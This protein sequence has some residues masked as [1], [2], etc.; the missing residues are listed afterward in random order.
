MY[1]DAEL[2]QCLRNCVQARPSAG[3]SGCLAF[4]LEEFLC[5]VLEAR[6][7]LR[8]P[9]ASLARLP[10]LL[11]QYRSQAPDCRLT[12][13]DLLLEGWLSPFLD[14]WDFS[15]WP[16]AEDLEGR[17]QPPAWRERV[18]FLRWL[19]ERVGEDRDI[20]VP[21][22]DR[23]LRDFQAIFPQMPCR[24]WFIQEGY[25]SPDGQCLARGRRGDRRAEAGALARLWTRWPAAQG[26]TEERADRWL[27]LAMALGGMWG[28]FEQLPVE[29]R[30]VLLERIIIRLERGRYPDLLAEN[31][32]IVLAETWRRSPE[33][34]DVQW[35]PLSGDIISDLYRFEHW[36]WDWNITLYRRKR[37]IH[38]YLRVLCD[39]LMLLE[40]E[41]LNRA[42]EVIALLAPIGC[43]HELSLPPES[44][45]CLW[46]N[47]KTSLLAC[48]RMFS[49]GLLQPKA[50]D[51]LLEQ[52]FRR[53]VE[54]L[55]LAPSRPA[56]GVELSRLLLFFARQPRGGRPDELGN[57]LLGQLLT[58][59]KRNRRVMEPQLETIACELGRRMEQEEDRLEWCCEFRLVC[60]LTR[61]LYYYRGGPP[62]ARD[63][64]SCRRLRAVLFNQYVR[65]FCTDVRFLKG[66][67]GLLDMDCFSGEV[68]GDIY[69]ER[70]DNLG[71]M[72]RFLQP[73][74]RSDSS[75][76]GR[77]Y[78]YGRCEIHLAML[79]ALMK[80]RKK[81]DP[82]LEPVFARFLTRVLLPE[83]NLL[84]FD[85]IVTTNGLPLVKEA[86]S[87][88]CAG[89]KNDEAFFQAL[90]RFDLPELVL[91]YCG[92]RDDALKQ[93]CLQLIQGQGEVPA[94]PIIHEEAL[95]QLILDGEIQC[96]YSMAERMLARQMDRW[97]ARPG[98]ALRQTEGRAADQLNRVWLLK[99]DYA[100]ILD[101]GTPFF[102]AVV[103]MESQEHR[104]LPRA[105]RIWQELLNERF[106][107]AYAINLI[108][109]YGLLYQEER[110][111]VLDRV[112]E[113]RERVEHGPYAS[114]GRQEK[115]HYAVNLFFLYRQGTTDQRKLIDSLCE[116]LGV[117]RDLF[118]KLPDRLEA[119]APQLEPVELSAENPVPALRTYCTAPLRQKAEWFFQMRS[120]DLEG[121]PRNALLTWCVMN[122]CAHLA[123][124]APQ[125]LVWDRLY[126]DRCTQLFRELFN[127]AYPQ[128]FSLAV[129]DQ[130]QTGRTASL[131]RQGQ[132]G[133]AEVDITFKE[134]GRVVAIGEALRLCSLEKRQ[135]CQHIHKL[136]GNN[137]LEVPM[138]LLV[139]VKHDQPDS[140]WQ[141][142]ESYV[143]EVF[144]RQ[145]GGTHWGPALV[146]E[147][148][149]CEDYIPGIHDSFRFHRHMLCVT[150][151]NLERRLPPMY[152]LFLSVGGQ[153][154]LSAAAAAR[155]KDGAR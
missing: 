123:A 132:A 120:C 90:E 53:I 13:E 18:A 78:A 37:V 137:L 133:I 106:Q 34:R 147:F 129:N 77:I 65:L 140:L 79:T 75:S 57:R 76:D 71:E 6:A 99:K 19:I 128:I 105:E 23:V 44:M 118:E 58:V 111:A 144:S 98:P 125:L 102:Q 50:W 54:K 31:R 3:G 46:N 61:E 127:Q 35:Q 30:R 12:A 40:D 130:E 27:D 8:A 94:H 63:V 114:W 80:C 11:E 113:L 20:F 51:H 108:Y 49:Q 59:L 122:T 154:T 92:A 85:S 153:E 82:V 55:L 109:T 56:D 110:N 121:D 142:Y 97:R 87:L 112:E 66:A 116:E 146:K 14:W 74:I 26:D 95:I 107:P 150:F 145:P 70:R 124:F 93:R 33:E 45:L 39:N 41:L 24:D 126:E 149:Q 52:A 148:A 100:R 134:Q 60:L 36:G 25:L 64:P 4:P 81:A 21:Q 143:R 103:Y 151:G 67:P 68:W 155:G 138:F 104:D 115:E 29:Q 89:R 16:G 48:E 136:L 7:E 22:F 88:V 86:A 101:R 38:S 96:L 135:I 73:D 2:L 69:Q 43:L 10:E 9:D 28:G 91:I 17:E 84:R 72:A 32:R 42:V 152:H 117:G 1:P 119:G 15:V 141:S 131:G 83:Q 139:Y 5:A 62:A 47:P